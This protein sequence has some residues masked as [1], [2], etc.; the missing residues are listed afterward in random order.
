MNINLIQ[1]LN[2][3][4]F[5]LPNNVILVAT[6]PGATAFTLILYFAHSH[7]SDFVS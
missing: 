7:A 6:Y 2:Q 1:Y 3:L 4:G 5:L